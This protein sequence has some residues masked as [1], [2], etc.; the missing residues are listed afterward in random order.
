M[1]IFNTDG[2]GET[3]V[4]HAVAEVLESAEEEYPA[5]SHRG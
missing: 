5:A 4:V 2:G 1:D 3:P